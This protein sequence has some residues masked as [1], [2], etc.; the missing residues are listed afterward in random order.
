VAETE[1]G[2]NVFVNGVVP[3]EIFTRP[4]GKHIYFQ[5]D[6]DVIEGP[7]TITVVAVDPLRN[8]AACPSTS[9]PTGGAVPGGPHAEGRR[10]SY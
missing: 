9:L 2:T 8:Q 3:R 10:A 6:V 1:V 5:M 7:N 4:D